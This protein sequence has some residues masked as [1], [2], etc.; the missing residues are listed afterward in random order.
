M[1]SEHNFITLSTVTSK[2]QCNVSDTVS[3][4]GAKVTIFSREKKHEFTGQLKN[5]G[6]SGHT[7]GT[8]LTDVQEST[9]VCGSDTSIDPKKYRTF[10]RPS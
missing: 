1:S 9:Q 4:T 7:T 5:T 3:K 8:V 6:N 10:S 2:H